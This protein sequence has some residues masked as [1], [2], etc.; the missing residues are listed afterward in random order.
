MEGG[1]GSSQ[2]VQVRRLER[3]G[4]GERRWR[5]G[6]APPPTDGA[7][8]DHEGCPPPPADLSGI[9]LAT[10]RERTSTSSAGSLLS[11][12]LPARSFLLPA[13]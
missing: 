11:H 2:Q 13:L 12:P 3:R 8:A 4:R 1:E 9:G 6:V 10:R 5:R 7:Q